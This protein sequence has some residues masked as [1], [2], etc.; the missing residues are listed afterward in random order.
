MSR[1]VRV[2]LVSALL[3]VAVGVVPAASETARAA[4]CQTFT[5][6]VYGAYG[7]QTGQFVFKNEWWKLEVHA[8]T[9]T[10]APGAY[11]TQCGATKIWYM[12]SNGKAKNPPWDLNN[13]V[14]YSWMDYRGQLDLGIKVAFPYGTSTSTLWAEIDLFPNGTSTHWEKFDGVDVRGVHDPSLCQSWFT[15]SNKHPC[16]TTWYYN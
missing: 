3:G 16:G 2:L 5:A 12:S 14:T 8:S 4:T 7:L 13:S 10:P 9:A 11:W 1:F 15:S 6:N